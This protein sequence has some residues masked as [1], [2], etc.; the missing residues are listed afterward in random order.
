MWA[1]SLV[2]VLAKKGEGS[3]NLYRSVTLEE[4]AI[5]DRVDP[6]QV[7][8]TSS[9]SDMTIRTLVSYI[10]ILHRKKQCI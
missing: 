7:P 4:D 10:S 6:V 8:G 9:S 1:G 3:R 2:L 5:P